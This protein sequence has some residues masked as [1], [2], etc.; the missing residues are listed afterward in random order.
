ME[1][2]NSDRELFER[3]VVCGR[4]YLGRVRMRI[5]TSWTTI[6]VIK[7][8]LYEDIEDIESAGLLVSDE[9]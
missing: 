9:T 2:L 1:Q 7:K 8:C 6:R 3:V 5:Q 4:L